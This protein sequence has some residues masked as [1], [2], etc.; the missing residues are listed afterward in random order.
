M[1]LDEQSIHNG[2][3]EYLS[4]L[5]GVLA[6]LDRRAIAQY[7]QALETARVN[8]NMVYTL[9]NGGSASTASH[10]VCDLNKSVS[11]GKNVR[12][13][14]VCLNDSLSTLMAYAND[15]GYADIFVEPLRNFCKPGDVV[16][17]FSGSGNSENVLRAFRYAREVGAMTVG[18]CGFEGGQLKGLSDL[19]IHVPIMDM[20]ISEDVH[21]AIHHLSI[22]LL[23]G[24]SC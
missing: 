7:I 3:D 18:F 10:V 15:V 11:Y 21:L 14:V 13:R 2:I 8:G 12:F 9:G 1:N 19:P 22:Q 16:V 5:H 17:G 24:R 20:E 6:A 23:R 4:K